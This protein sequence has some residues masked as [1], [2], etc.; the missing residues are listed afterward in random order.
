M[1]TVNRKAQLWIEP[2]RSAENETALHEIR[3]TLRVTGVPRALCALAGSETALPPLWAALRPNAETRAF[4]E[5]AD[6]LRDEAVHAA[7]GV[8]RLS[9]LGLAQ[10]GESQA[11]QA[12]AALM[13][14]HYLDPKLLLL[15]SATAFALE[16]GPASPLSGRGRGSGELIERGA[17]SRMPPLELADEHSA[18]EPSR[19]A[20]REAKRALGV[21][22]APVELLT[23]ALWPRYLGAAWQRL[24]P[25][26]KT[27][28]FGAARVRLQALS[29]E[30]ARSLPY[31]VALPADPQR[32]ETA[33]ALERELSALVVVVSLLVLD[34]EAPS[35]ARRSPYP[36]GPRLSQE[37]L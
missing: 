26:M 34:W 1:I 20:L 18:D 10:L 6:R 24:K 14:Y 27:E 35:L 28:T 31:H 22:A 9:V 37:S 33:R 23:L 19:K 8:D 15:S 13:L 11:Y 5:G 12:E 7:A 16:S 30:Q 17:P 2:S 3:Q 29:R 4:E 21:P 36:A 32:L 25:V